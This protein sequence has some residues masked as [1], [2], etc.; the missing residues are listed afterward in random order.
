[1]RLA[2]ALIITV[3]LCACVPL[4]PTA[5]QE[6]APAP[7]EKPA[8]APVPVPKPIEQPAPKPAEPA[9]A[10]V[11][12][13]SPPAPKQEASSLGPRECAQP[14]CLENYPAFLR[15]T[16]M[17][18][19]TIVVGDDAPSTDVIAA[20]EITAALTAHALE[21]KWPYQI[22]SALASEIS[23]TAG[24]IIAIGNA[25]DND[26][27]KK[28]LN[29][30][31]CFGATDG[32]T[33]IRL[34]PQSEGIALIITGDHASLIRAAARMLAKPGIYPMSGGRICV[35][36]TIETPLIIPC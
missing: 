13:P 28:L 16:A 36:G 25:C 6:P 7:V 17:L 8:P 32:K 34:I 18:D 23:S 35:D 14:N 30:T 29:R 27:V 19:L 12:A 20:N 10:P 26:L 4:E 1:M 21:N 31:S 33:I 9:P 24:S 22:H 5:P 11:P 2:I 3:L 15:R